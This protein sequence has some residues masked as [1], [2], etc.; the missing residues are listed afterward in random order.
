M[1]TVSSDRA[2]GYTVGLRGVERWQPP[3]P[4]TTARGGDGSLAE[5]RSLSDGIADHPAWTPARL[6]K[7]FTEYFHNGTEG[8]ADVRHW[9]D[10]F[11]SHDLIFLVCSLPQMEHDVWWLLHQRHRD[12]LRLPERERART[13]VVMEAPTKSEATP[14]DEPF[15]P[16]AHLRHGPAGLEI[17]EYPTW[18]DAWT[19]VLGEWW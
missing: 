9:V 11:L 7:W 2:I 5:R 10:V 13:V 1:C 6:A 18:D 15:D 3:T 8:P 16:H 14:T 19:K 12:M 4:P 17:V